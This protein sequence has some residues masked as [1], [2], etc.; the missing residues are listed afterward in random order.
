MAV[1]R[2]ETIP[3][4]IFR[5][6]VCMLPLV[7]HFLEDRHIY[8][9]TDNGVCSIVTWVYHILGLSVLVRLHSNGKFVE[10]RFSSSEV[11]I[12][13]VRL[14]ELSF[15][16]SSEH[17][18]TMDSSIT[19]LSS[20]DKEKLFKMVADPDENKIDATFKR[21]AYRYG[22]DIVNRNLPLQD[23]REKVAAEI[24]V[25]VTAFAICILRALYIPDLLFLYEVSEFRIYESAS[26]LFANHKMKKKKVDEYVAKYSERALC[27]LQAPEA[28]YAIIKDW[29]GALEEDTEVWPDLR[30]CA[31]LL[32][33]LVLTFAHVSDLLAASDLP[34]C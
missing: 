29:P 6:L 27:K 5:G 34:L 7:Q 21:L 11:I 2:F 31:R 17:I 25:I 19:L 32:G 24:E 18:W 30:L 16:P 3:S 1:P 14:D 8:L 20:S 23:G 9:E 12:I 28:I 15:S 33:I 4:V 13:D 26:L 10:Y 22:S